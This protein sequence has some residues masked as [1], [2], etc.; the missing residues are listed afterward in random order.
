MSSFTDRKVG[1]PT[2]AAEIGRTFIG[3][4]GRI[5]DLSFSPHY[6]TFASASEDGTCKIWDVTSKK[7]IASLIHNKESEALRVS[8]MHSNDDMVCTA[9]SDGLVNVWQ[10]FMDKS[11]RRTERLNHGSDSQIYSCQSL[12]T[13]SCKPSEIMTAADNKLFIWNIEKPSEPT[14]YQFSHIQHG[15]NSNSS[16]DKSTC[17][18][19]FGGQRNPD[20]L[21]FV[22]DAAANPHE[23]EVVAMALSDSTIRLLDLR[24]RSQPS[25][26]AITMNAN[27]GAG[28]ISTESLGHATGVGRFALITTWI[29]IFTSKIVLFYNSPLVLNTI[30]TCITE[31]WCFEVLYFNKFPGLF[32]LDHLNLYWCIDWV[33]H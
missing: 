14:V 9:G 5:F 7:C 10:R 29:V 17:P 24:N 18:P 4:K 3:H 19:V 21:V 8:F 1:T 26:F 23:P 31:I 16:N 20:N 33:E 15:N 30:S 25:Q 27:F 28:L 11:F 32:F 13:T 12:L 2:L 22:F 6:K